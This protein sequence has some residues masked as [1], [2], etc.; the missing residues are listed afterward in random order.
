MRNDN[1]TSAASEIAQWIF[2]KLHFRNQSKAL[3]KMEYI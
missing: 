3:R 1:L 2:Q